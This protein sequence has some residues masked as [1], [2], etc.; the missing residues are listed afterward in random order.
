MHNKRPPLPSF[1]E[2][3][4]DIRIGKEKRNHVYDVYNG[5]EIKIIIIS[6][7]LSLSLDLSFLLIQSSLSFSVT[8]LFLFW[9]YVTLP[10]PLSSIFLASATLCPYTTIIFCLFVIYKING[11]FILTWLKMF[12]VVTL[13]RSP[14]T[15]I[16]NM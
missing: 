16:N 5:E 8:V 14:S 7:P 4:L 1:R 12:I 2:C 15:C 3:L 11:D 10:H 9:L 6:C 13:K